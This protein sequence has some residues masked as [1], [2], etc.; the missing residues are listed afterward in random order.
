MSLNKSKII[1]NSKFDWSKT[2]N[3][4]KKNHQLK[5]NSA[6]GSIIISREPYNKYV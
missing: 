3:I 6:P 2:S 1:N 4:I 5:L